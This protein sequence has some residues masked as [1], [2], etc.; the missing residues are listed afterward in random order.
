MIKDLLRLKHIYISFCRLGLIGTAAC[1]FVEK[2]L[3]DTLSPL[4]PLHLTSSGDE[5]NKKSTEDTS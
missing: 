4:L 5:V 2:S 3:E 1:L